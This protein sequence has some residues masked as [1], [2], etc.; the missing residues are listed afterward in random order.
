M[1]GGRITGTPRTVTSRVL[2]ILDAFQPDTTT[3]NLTQIS[4]RT[5]LPAS[6]AHRLLVELTEWGA[7]QRDPD[8]R[9]HL[10]PRLT[11][12]APSDDSR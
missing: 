11:R 12:A 1:S 8:L 6:T 2:A 3:L 4:Q 5:G 9:Y 7:L 10:G